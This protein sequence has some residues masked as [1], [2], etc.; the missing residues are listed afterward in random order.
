MTAGISAAFADQKAQAVVRRQLELALVDS[1]KDSDQ[2]M[3]C[4]TQWT[5]PHQLGSRTLCCT[6]GAATRALLIN[7]LATVS[8]VSQD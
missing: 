6:A 1:G 7:R 3:V 5:F 2:G 4:Y 8:T